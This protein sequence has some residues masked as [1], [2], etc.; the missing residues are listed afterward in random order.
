M[1][2]KFEKSVGL[3]GTFTGTFK[4]FGTKP[5]YKGPPLVTILLENVSDATGKVT[6]DHLWF[7]SGKQWKALDLKPGDKV[8]FDARITPYEKGYKGYHDDW[9]A[10]AIETDYRLSFPTHM[11]KLLP[12]TKMALDTLPLFGNS[13]SVTGETK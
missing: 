10:P 1:R 6:C 2:D 11:K 7:V 3:R 9:D 4:R 12:D 13:Q 5:A 8:Q